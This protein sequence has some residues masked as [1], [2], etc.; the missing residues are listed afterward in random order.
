LRL[1]NKDLQLRHVAEP[2]ARKGVQA[3]TCEVGQIERDRKMH[4]TQDNSGLPLAGRR[5][6]L[7]EDEVIVA[8]DMEWELMAAG[9]E[10]VGPAHRLAEAL[11]MADGPLDAAVLDI[12]LAGEKVWPLA[13]RLAA[14][15]VPFVLASANVTS[16]DMVPDWA[17]RHAFDKPV[18]MAA[19]VATL[20][21]FSQTRSMSDPKP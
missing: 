13:E 2:Q 18:P 1:R 21:H 9:A 8:M 17:R 12:N 11:A 4:G 14:A 10:V 19:L 6:L 3:S 16:V 5:I 7:V 15:G 20:A